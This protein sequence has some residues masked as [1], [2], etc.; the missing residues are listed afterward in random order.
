MMHQ[1]SERSGCEHPLLTEQ[2]GHETLVVRT[3]FA[4]GSLPSCSPSAEMRK[5]EVLLMNRCE[6]RP[7]HGGRNP[8][9]PCLEFG[10]AR[11]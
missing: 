1:L 6:R 11:R 8:L 3:A 7:L 2:Q 5:T 10:R 4:S 9:A